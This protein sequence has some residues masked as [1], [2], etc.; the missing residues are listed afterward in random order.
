MSRKTIQISIP[1]AGAGPAA[2]TPAP[3]PKF[4]AVEAGADS[5]VA[6]APRLAEPARV[7]ILEPQPARDEG[8]AFTI[9]LSAQPDLFEA[10]KIFYFLPQAALWF[11]GFGLAQ[12]T[13]RGP[14]GPR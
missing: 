5:W 2:P 10:A 7:E 6:Q 12:R 1:A 3:A 11:W 8:L 14:L 13:L 4:A 9:R